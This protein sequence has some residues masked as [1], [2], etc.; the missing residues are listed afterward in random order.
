M[1]E[2]EVLKCSADGA[3]YGSRMV[4]VRREENDET[5][6]LAVEVADTPPKP[7]EKVNEEDFGHYADWWTKYVKRDARILG[8]GA[9]RSAKSCA[10]HDETRWLV[11]SER[12]QNMRMGFRKYGW[13]QKVFL[14]EKG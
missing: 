2:Y 5:K 1:T 13:Y 11:F 4:E 3:L 12:G 7:A 6:L 14:D 8:T 9:S 10:G